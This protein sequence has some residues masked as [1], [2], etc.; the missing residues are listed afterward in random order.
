MARTGHLYADEK[1]TAA[2]HTLATGDYALRQRLEHAWIGALVRLDADRHFPEGEI[3]DRWRELRSM[4]EIVSAEEA[5]GEGTLVA[6]LRR[7]SDDDLRRMAER[8]VEL[9]EWAVIDSAGGESS[10]PPP[11]HW[12]EN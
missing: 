1:L 3:R 4:V 7:L 11:V 2:V 6:S 5:A 8:I 10:P 12:D 9:Y